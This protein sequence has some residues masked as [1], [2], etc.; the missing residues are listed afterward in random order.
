MHG[1]ESVPLLV[2]P[3]TVIPVGSREDKP[4]YNYADAPTFEVFA[5]ADGTTASA[6]LCGADGS[7]RVVVDVCR[8]GGVVIA[9][10]L[11]G[12]ELLVSG[13][14]LRI[15]TGPLGADRGPLG[16]AAGGTTVIELKAP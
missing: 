8:T 7:E 15:V 16:V 1:F 12:A 3:G 6:R 9:K 10:V 2:R 11:T 13:W 4:D 5:L 14:S